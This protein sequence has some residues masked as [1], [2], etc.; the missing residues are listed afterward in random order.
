MPEDLCTI[1]RLEL[2]ERHHHT[3]DEAYGVREQDCPG[4]NDNNTIIELQLRDAD[5]GIEKEDADKCCTETVRKGRRVAIKPVS[6]KYIV[7]VPLCFSL[8]Q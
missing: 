1:A 8:L 5:Q 7:C 4:C 3:A 2:C 6:R